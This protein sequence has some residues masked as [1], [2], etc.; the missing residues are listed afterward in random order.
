MQQELRKVEGGVVQTE[1]ISNSVVEGLSLG[2]QRHCK[3]HLPGHPLPTWETQPLRSCI[4]SEV[5]QSP[6]ADI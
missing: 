6:N 2:C 5:H 1:H 3:R 4:I